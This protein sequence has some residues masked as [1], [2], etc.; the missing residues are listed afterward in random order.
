MQNYCRGVLS[1]MGWGKKGKEIGELLNELEN[2]L[3]VL[4]QA[5]CTYVCKFANKSLE[6]AKYP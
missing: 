3:G 1:G 6:L 4:W 2:T 5:M